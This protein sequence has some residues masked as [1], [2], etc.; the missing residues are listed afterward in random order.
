MN[1]L[2]A[3]YGVKERNDL[4]RD[5]HNTVKMR[6][7]PVIEVWIVHHNSEQMEFREDFW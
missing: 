4:S 2:V 3:V 6:G 1:I 5:Q 7:Q